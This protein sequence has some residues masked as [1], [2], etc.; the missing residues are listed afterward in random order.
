MPGVEVEQL[1]KAYPPPLTWRRLLS[2]AGP[3]SRPALR[4]VSF[5]IR[6][7][8]LVAL[9]GPNGAGKTT[10]LRI[11]AGLLLPD[12]GRARVQGLDVVRDRPASRAQVGAAFAE[13]RGMSGRLTGF[14][15]LEF[16]AALYGLHR[17]EAAERIRLLAGKLEAAA[18]LH[19]EARTLSTGERARLIL[20]RVLLHRPRVLLLDELTRALDPGAAQRLRRQISEQLRSTGA[21]A[22]FASHD[23]AEVEALASRVV[24]LHQGRV[25]AFGTMEE[26]RARAAEVFSSAEAAG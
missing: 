13:D 22:L 8:E 14:Q 10:L 19:R 20:L 23:L 6:E 24:L 4:E 21:C 5:D 17:A 16:Y 12:G 7:G 11:L 15:N 26:V 25:A 9:I 3:G 18:L 2:R 1:S